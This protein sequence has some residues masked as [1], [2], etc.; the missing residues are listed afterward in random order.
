MGGEGAPLV[1]IGEKYLFK[2][3]KLFLNLGGISNLAFG[4]TA[5]DISFCNLVLNLLYVRLA[6]NPT[7]DYDPEGQTA[8]AG[9]FELR[10]IIST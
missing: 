6:E 7:T 3:H 8:R 10:F 1:P 2:D 9:Q 5:F 4:Q